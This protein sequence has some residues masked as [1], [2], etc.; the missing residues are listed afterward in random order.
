VVE[1]VEVVD[2]VDVVEPPAARAT[3]PAKRAGAI[4]G[5]K[6]VASSTGGSAKHASSSLLASSSQSIWV[7]VA[8]SAVAAVAVRAKAE[9]KRNANLG[10]WNSL[11]RFASLWSKETCL[12]TWLNVTCF[13]P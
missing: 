1:V 3:P 7:S 13:S 2:V 12:Q 11:F 6:L 4:P 10:M 9:S 8:T 5:K